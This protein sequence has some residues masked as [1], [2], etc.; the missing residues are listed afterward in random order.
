MADPVPPPSSPSPMIDAVTASST[1]PAPIPPEVTPQGGKG[2]LLLAGVPYAAFVLWCLFLLAVLPNP[3][4]EAKSLV[5]I[6]ILTTL[7][8]LLA[9]VAVGLLALK[10]I[11]ASAT[12]IETRRR[13]L[14]IVGIL[15]LPGVLLGAVTPILIIREPSLRIDIVEPTAAADLV[16]PVAVTLSAERA[17]GILRNLGFRAV[18]YQWD[19]DGD[20]K[21][22]DET[23]VPT[24]TILYERLG[25]YTPVVRIILDGGGF[26]RLTRRVSIP[27]A[28][29][30]VTP[31]QPV[32]EKAIKFSVAGLLT[33]SK[34]FK[35]VQWDFGD[36]NPPV[37]V[38][39]P[40]TAYTYY[41][42][43]DYS[44]TAVLQLQNQS[45]ITYKRVIP[46][47]EPEPLPFPITLV[48]EPKT[49]IGPIPFGV[50]FRLVTDVPLKE[51][52]W[53]FGDGKEDRGANLLRE[54]HAF[55]TV[56]VFPVVVRARSDDGTIAELTTIVRATEVLPLQGLQSEG[57]PPVQNNIIIGEVPVEI[58]LTPKTVTP[59]VQFSW[60]IPD[61]L[62]AHAEG[63]TLTGIFR[64]EGKY[65]VTLMAQGAEGKSMRQPITIEV[66]PPSAEPTIL[67]TPDGGT[68]PLAVTFDASQ[69]FVP[70]GE[71]VAGF[72]WLFGDE[73]QGKELPQ[74]G[75]ARVEHT[76][77][78]PGEYGIT[79]SVVLISGK[80]FTTQRTI[81]VRKPTL[82]AC[83]TAS[84]LTLQAGKG[85]EFDSS[86]STGDSS[87]LLWDIRRD[88]DPDVVQAQSSDPT[89]VYVFDEPGEYTVSL[90]LKDSYG[91]QD[92]KTITISVS[93]SE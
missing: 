7:G 90:S 8:G 88:D 25:V 89:Y 58:H 2:I 39:T 15:L 80:N 48:S 36:G 22:N 72:K 12:S 82:T 43:G 92:K 35:Q 54:S 78:A 51:V 66:K 93:P 23:V 77:Q 13:S 45:Q 63:G 42:V 70:P 67:L 79:L 27:T 64:K 46:V 6:G 71:T 18:K 59:L 29:F 86:C 19:T 34:L 5:S 20:G 24:T 62:N 10:R 11:S 16:A 53:S 57:Q 33:D 55:E 1:A 3:T 21:P 9:F 26:R 84:R 47:R 61:D 17:T 37:T 75:A 91:N 14:I 40:D 60:E 74:L 30:S 73:G 32:V 76:Y 49:L 28:V 38:T 4:G 87:S 68:A 44:V 41:T 85:V 56:G 81:V 31:V 69:S 65:T 50:L 83:L 52:V